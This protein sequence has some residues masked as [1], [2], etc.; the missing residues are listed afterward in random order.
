MVLEAEERRGVAQPC[1]GRHAIAEIHPNQ[2]RGHDAQRQHPLEDRGAFPPARRRQAL[3]QVERNH[4]ADQ[5]AA[6]P[7]QQ[8]PEEQRPIAV[9]ERDHRNAHDKSASAHDH[10]RLAPHPIGQ[11]PG[12]QRGKH[13]PQQHRGHDRRKLRG[14]KPRSR[15]QVRVGSADDAHVD[16]VEQPAQSRHQQQE[17]VIAP[18]R[19]GIGRRI[20][21]RIAGCIHRDGSLFFI[22]RLLGCFASRHA[23]SCKSPVYNGR[24]TFKRSTP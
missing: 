23:E 10:Q 8:P 7:L 1:H 19:G 24:N 14:R 3:G 20:G 18:H 2:R 21:V 9:R 12:K 16:P 5:P 6:H 22:G 13:A 15:R 11:Q 17:C 4:N